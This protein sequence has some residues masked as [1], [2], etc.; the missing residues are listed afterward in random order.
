MVLFIF[1]F[2]SLVEQ[3]KYI[4]YSIFFINVCTR[5]TIRKGAL[6]EWLDGLHTLFRRV[7]PG[8]IPTSSRFLF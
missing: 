5:P 3:G 7:V 1:L 6:A 4:Y 2:I 8:S